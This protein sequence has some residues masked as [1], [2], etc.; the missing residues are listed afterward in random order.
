MNTV[1]KWYEVMK[2]NDMD[3]LDELLAEDVVFYSPVVFTPQKGKE[4]TKMYLMAA[5]GVFGEGAKKEVSDSNK[6]QSNF[7]YI[8]EIIGEK[9]ALLEFES[10]M[11]GIYING[12]DLISWNEEGKITEF[13]VIV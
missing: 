4:I 10:E 3:E 8:K 1:E 5:G 2:S 13:K 9:S 11:D 7:K 12:V 6:N